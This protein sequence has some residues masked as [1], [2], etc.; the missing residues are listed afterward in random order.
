MAAGGGR[1]APARRWSNVHGASGDTVVM[2]GV[3][4]GRCV[5]VRASVRVMGRRT[6]WREELVAKWR[7][8]AK[9]QKWRDGGITPRY[10]G[11]N[12]GQGRQTHPRGAI[13]LDH[14]PSRVWRDGGKKDLPSSHSPR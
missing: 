11:T 4:G 8:S 12:D 1:A 6:K 10:G 3:G 7:E 5:G 13:S 9:K 2:A 14:L